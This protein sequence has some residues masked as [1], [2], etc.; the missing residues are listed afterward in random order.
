V[1]QRHALLGL[2]LVLTLVAAGCTDRDDDPVA[3]PN[4]S[5]IGVGSSESPGGSGDGEEGSPSESPSSE[6]PFTEEDSVLDVAIPEP[7]TLDP[8]RVQDPGSVLVARQL[9]EGL[10]KWDPVAEEVVPAAALSWEAKKKGRRF[11]FELDPDATFHD[12]SPVTAADFVYAFDRIA[13]KKSGS[14]LAYTLELVEGF[15]ATNGFGDAKHLSGLKARG[16]TKLIIDLVRSF[17]EF[18]TVLTHPGLVPVLKDDVEKIDRFLANPIGNGPFKMAQRWAPGKTVVLEAFDGALTTPELDGVRFVSFPDAVRSWIP[19]TNG[20]Y[21]V[22]E[23]PAGQIEAAKEVY[24]GDGY[25]PFLAGY[26]YGFNLEAPEL[27][28]ERLRLAVGRAVDRRTIARHIYKGTMIEPR[29]IVPQGMPGFDDNVCG[30]L[31][32]F[33]PEAAAKL[34]A[35]LPRKERRISIEFTEGEPHGT[36]A[37]FIKKNLTAV[38]LDV[39]VKGYPLEKYLE[40]LSADKQSTYR[41]G[42]IAE[43]PSPAVFLSSLFRSDSPDNHTAFD[44]G[45]VDQVLENAEGAKSES[46]RLKLYRKAEKMIVKAAPIVPIGSFETHWAAQGYVEGINFDTT[47]GFDAV[48]VSLAPAG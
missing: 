30:K 26:Y 25:V 32:A 13:R 34:V 38:G 20:E 15:D 10:T 22:A 42:W 37:K 44:S 19:F 46:K 18:P 29:G 7:A 16:K 9:F 47:G 4:A 41:L 12:G 43:Y 21:D 11:V 6:G 28:D 48:D 35:Q 31:C 23:V 36:V 3:G 8:M 5:A 1:R 33:S 39:T 24:G 40:R 27:G 17:Y 2:I 14:E 45:I